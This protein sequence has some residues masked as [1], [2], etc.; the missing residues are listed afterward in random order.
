MPF[1]LDDLALFGRIAVLG[2]LSAAARER[3]V[4]V[5][6]VT[7]TLQRLEAACGVRLMHR[8]THGLS[9]TDE[10]DTLLRHGQDLLETAE[11][12]NADLQVRKGEPSGWVRVSAS[13]SLAEAVLV[14]S[15]PSL[16]ER[17][18]RLR[19]DLVVE[20]PLA[21]LAR[22]GIDIALR[23]GQV[24]SEQLVARTL[25]TTSRRLYASPAYLARHPA[26]QHPDDLAHHHLIA[27]RKVPRMNLWPRCDGGP[28]LQVTGQTVTDNAGVLL[29]M[30][31]H[32]V[33]IARLLEI[34]ARPWVLRGEL[35]PVLPGHF[36]VPDIPVYAVMRPERYRLPKVR[37]CL[38]HWAAS[39]EVASIER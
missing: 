13:A 6:Q 37:A 2:S 28:A 9:L 33:G 5:S 36:D 38:A 34:V 15:L 22:D 18:P 7:R 1:H 11:V 29:T 16:S 30:V 25:A 31:R 21:D 27:H 17:H 8:S 20:D 24:H 26:P 23:T 4:P 39:L 19:V 10:G 35:V 14:P 32:G 3:N 12:L